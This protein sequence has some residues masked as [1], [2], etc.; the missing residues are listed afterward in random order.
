MWQALIATSFEVSEFNSI[1]PLCSVMCEQISLKSG[2]GFNSG[3]YWDKLNLPIIGKID[4]LLRFAERVYCSR[5]DLKF[6]DLLYALP[7]SQCANEDP[8]DNYVVLI[9]HSLASL[10]RPAAERAVPRFR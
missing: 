4:S 5:A 1:V 3:K 9:R 6:P 2:S 10:K 8:S 7:S